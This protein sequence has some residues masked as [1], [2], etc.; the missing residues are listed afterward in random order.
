MMK[1]RS[2]LFL[3]M[4]CL[5]WSSWADTVKIGTDIDIAARTMGAA[6]YKATNVAMGPKSPVE[7]LRMWSVD[8]GVLIAEYSNK[9]RKIV[10]L[11]F[12]LTDK[13]AKFQFVVIGFD[14]PNGEMTLQTRKPNSGE[15]AAP[16]DGDKP[17]S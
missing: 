10:S 9:T 3:V 15:H 2:I 16:S 12:W 14:A 1:L 6:G 5:P 7:N 13:S 17:S 11:G 4:L 8:S